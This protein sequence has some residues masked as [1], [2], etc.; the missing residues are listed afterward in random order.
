MGFGRVGA[1][2]DVV[3]FRNGMSG[4][5]SIHLHFT[6]P[7]TQT[8]MTHEFEVRVDSAMM[9]AAWRAWFFRER[10]LTKL[11]LLMALVLL[12]SLYVDYRHGGLGIFSV[13]ILSMIAMVLLLFGAVYFH[14]LRSSLSK[15]DAINDGRAA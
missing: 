6:K 14:G 4:C 1:L 12:G 3:V 13:I 5:R 7:A 15:L 9:K 2:D 8:Q 10:R 11:D